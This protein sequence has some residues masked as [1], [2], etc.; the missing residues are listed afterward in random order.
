MTYRQ[1]TLWTRPSPL[2]VLAVALAMFVPT[3]LA[4]RLFFQLNPK[5]KVGSSGRIYIAPFL[6]QSNKTLPNTCF[7]SEPYSL[8]LWKFSG[9]V[10]FMSAFM[11]QQKQLRLASTNLALFHAAASTP[12]A[13][14]EASCVMFKPMAVPSVNVS[15]IIPEISI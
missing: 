4:K 1:P 14:K 8:S 5:Y 9:R 3:R 11:Y 2:Y 12:S 10:D 6:S 15:I 13:Q 7:A